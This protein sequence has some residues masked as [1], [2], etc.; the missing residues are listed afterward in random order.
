[1]V[2]VTCALAT[3]CTP[4]GTLVGHWRE[5]DTGVGHYEYTFFGDGTY[6]KDLVANGGILEDTGHWQAGSAFDSPVVTLVEADPYAAIGSTAGP[7]TTQIF[8]LLKGDTLY[9]AGDQAGLNAKVQASD[10]FAR[11]PAN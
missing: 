9:I 8:Y 5:K 11:V 6:K 7:T 2:L 3:G 1:M 4:N 10:G